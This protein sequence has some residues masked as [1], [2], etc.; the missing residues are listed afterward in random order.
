MT[1]TPGIRPAVFASRARSA[2]EQVLRDLGIA[3]L[4]GDYPEGTLLPGEAELTERY[5]SPAPCCAR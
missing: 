1:A 4:R 5:A 2:Q 3:I